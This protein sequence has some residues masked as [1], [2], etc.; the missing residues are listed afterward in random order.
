MNR[1]LEIERAIRQRDVDA[2]IVLMFDGNTPRV[3]PGFSTE[4]ELWDSKNGCPRSLSNFK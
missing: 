3:R 1:N 4:T 2:V